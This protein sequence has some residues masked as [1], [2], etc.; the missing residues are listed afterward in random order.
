MAMKMN[1]NQNQFKINYTQQYVAR[2][3]VPL[4]EPIIPVPQMSSANLR[5]RRAVVESYRG[6]Q[7]APDD[8]MLPMPPHSQAQSMSV[9]L[10]DLQRRVRDLKLW[11]RAI[12]LL[13]KRI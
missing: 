11:E 9:I 6:R 10:Q 2:I 8:A 4:V 7:I 5:V 13:K 12:R 1:Q 3:T